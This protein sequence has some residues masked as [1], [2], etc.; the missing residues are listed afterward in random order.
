MPFGWGCPEGAR[1]L[2]AWAH[3]SST[4]RIHPRPDFGLGRRP[5]GWRPHSST[6]GR[7]R[8]M[9]QGG[10]TFAARMLLCPGLGWGRPLGA[11]HSGQGRH[12]SVRAASATRPHNDRSEFRGLI[13]ISAA[14]R[15]VGGRTPRPTDGCA[16]CPSAAQHSL[17]ACCSA[18]GLVGVAPWGLCIPARAVTIPFAPPPPHDRTTIA[19]NPDRPSSETSHLRSTPN[20]RDIVH[21][22]FDID[23]ADPFATSQPAS[24]AHED[25]L[26]GFRDRWCPMRPT[27]QT[28][29]QRHAIR[30]PIPA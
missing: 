24:W 2:G 17:H 14:A 4:A 5:P 15:Q 16:R 9:T 27:N 30:R 6:D 7:V 1:Q 29:V 11:L 18:L 8:P 20:A 26:L 21:D 23:I 28:C 10:A 22:R 13:S 12:H 3:V 25:P 19:A